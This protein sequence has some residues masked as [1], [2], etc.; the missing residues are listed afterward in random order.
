MSVGNFIPRAE[1]AKDVGVSLKIVKQFLNDAVEKGYE[2]HSLMVVRHGKVAVEWYNEPYNKDTP[3][4]VYSIS[5]SFTSTAIGFAI[6]EG[7][8]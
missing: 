3:Q 6:N 7:L 2:F 4:V 1:S 5:K 8:E